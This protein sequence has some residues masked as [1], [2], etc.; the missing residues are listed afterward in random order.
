MGRY[1]IPY[2][3]PNLSDA[4]WGYI[5]GFLDADGCTGTYSAGPPKTNGERT[6]RPVI[7]FT[8]TELAPLQLMKEWLGCGSILLANRNRKATYKATKDSWN[9]QISTRLAVR[10]VLIRLIPLLVIKKERAQKVVDG[11]P[12]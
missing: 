1:R 11:I 12:A 7:V 8:N 10:G 5:A 2:S 3:L 4:Q 9:Y 6:P